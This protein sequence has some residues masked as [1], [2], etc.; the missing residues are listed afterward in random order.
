[1]KRWMIGCFWALL[2]LPNLL[3][4]A[5]SHMLEEENTENRVLAEFPELDGENIQGYPRAVEDYINDH[6]A[7]RSYFL[8]LNAG[9]NLGIF[10]SV[11]N[12]DVV[13]GK[14]GWYFFNGGF[15]ILDYRGQDLYTQEELDQIAGKMEEVN[16][17]FAS[18]GIEFAVVLAPNKE[19]IYGEYMPEYYTKLSDI[20]RYDQLEQHLAAQTSIPVVAPKQYFLENRELLWYFKTDTHWNEAGGFVASQMLIDALGGQSVP[21]EDV[22]IPYDYRGP[23]DLALLFHMPDYF[24]EDYFCSVHGYYDHIEPEIYDPIGDGMVSRSFAEE[25]PDCRRIAFY[26]DSFAMGMSNTITKYFR[27]VDYYHWSGFSPEYLE[28]YPPDIMVY[29]V[30]EREFVRILNDM[31]QLLQVKTAE[32]KDK[33]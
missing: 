19:E 10:R 3:W 20:T 32:E 21:V 26:R 7:F 13:L 29:E 28:E 1:M 6:A 30:V 24:L 31:N 23:G 2:M 11:D 15:S 33:M 8:S 22:I 14:D 5:A 16:Q 18:Q 9:I 17:H 27:N 12:P 25:A 4:P